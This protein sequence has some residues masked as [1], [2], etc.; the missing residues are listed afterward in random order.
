MA[1][2]KQ[3]RRERIKMRIRKKDTGL[4]PRL[5]VFMS[6][7][8]IYAQII[9]DSEKKTL[10]VASSKEKTF[11]ASGTKTE[12][13]KAVG[14]ILAERAKEAKIEQVFFDRNGYLYHGR[15]KALADAA[16]E[17]GLIF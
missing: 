2:S 6:N 1:I 3:Y 16:R 11:E 5:S 4:L 9:N 8:E 10:V 17:A 14:T 13:A 15:V 7:K 12:K